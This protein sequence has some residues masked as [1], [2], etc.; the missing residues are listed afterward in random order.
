MPKSHLSAVNIVGGLTLNSAVGTNGQVLT[1]GGTGNPTW[2][3]VITPTS[4]YFAGHN[5]EGRLMYNTYLTNDM[6]N[7][8]LRGSAVAA[9]QN[10][11]SYSI[12]N[13]NWDAMFDGTATFFNISPTSGF[14]FPLVIT[15]PLPRT[16]TFGAWVGLS[17]GST[18][19]RAN[20]VTIE[21]FSLDSSSWVT[22]FTTTSNTSEDIFTAVS[23]LVNGNAT[24]INQ[25]R[26]TISSPNSTQLRLQH[27]WAYN[28]N[29][30]MWS[31]TMMPRA[32][33]TIYGAITVPDR[34]TLKAV[35]NAANQSNGL[36]LSNTV[37][38][39][40]SGVYLRTDGSGNPRLSLL[41][42]T[43]ALGEAVSIDSAAKV[44]FNNVAPTGQVDITTASTTRVPLIIRPQA[45]QSADMLQVRNAANDANLL[46]IDS[47]GNL[48]ASNVASL[49][50]LAQIAEANSGGLIVLGRATAQSSSPGLNAGSIYFRDGTT[51]GTLRLATRT[52]ASG[53][54]ETIVDNISSTGSTAGARFVGAGG[55]NTAGNVVYHIETNARTAN[56]TLALVDDGDVV[57]MNVASANTV[58]IPLNSS[59]A[60]PIGTQITVIQTGTGQTSIAVTSGVTLNATPVTGTNN[61]K[62]RAQW[63]SLTLLKRGTDT[64]IAMGDLT[65]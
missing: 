58:T 31:Q 62:L 44:G 27:L 50:S 5:P 23:G 45:S 9:T 64:W 33:G 3:T 30:D 43:G 7:A 57:E 25:V 35:A 16:L 13:A 63:S 56:Y 2:T 17:F 51:S 52:G 32:G 29:S 24:G 15:V 41:A 61:A 65:A 53:V 39:W 8:R 1:S 46:R 22:V 42:P 14:T 38:A 4:S 47:G 19:F 60:F 55:V 11:V 49:N 12:S 18:T 21:V 34:I 40:Q 54:E 59:V 26:Y 36:L 6:A 37:D 48:K 10:G 28:F 20:S